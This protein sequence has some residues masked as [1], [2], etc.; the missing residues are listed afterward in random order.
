MTKINNIKQN[1]YDQC[2]SFIDIRFHTIQHTINE[3][4]ESLTSET[5]SS[6]GDKHET[7]RAMLQLEREKA[8]QQLAEIQKTNQVLSKIDVSKS[9]E[10]IGLG[11]VVYTT[12][13][14]YFVAVSAGEIL[15]AS[16]K[17]YAISAITPIAQLLLGKTVD[18]TIQFRDQKF[19][20]IRVI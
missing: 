9:S 4:Q 1:L 14:N 11:C 13:A 8:G 16:E 18:D 19:K 12:Q 17:F 20:I 3:I 10:I 5:K 7:G 2:Q 15:V 6:A